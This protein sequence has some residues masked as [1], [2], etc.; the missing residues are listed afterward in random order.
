MLGF[1][2]EHLSVT[3]LN[4]ARARQPLR[5]SI[6]LTASTDLACVTNA[7]SDEVLGLVN[8]LCKVSL[9]PHSVSRTLKSVGLDLDKIDSLR[10]PTPPLGRGLVMGELDVSGALGCRLARAL[11]R[12]R[13]FPPSGQVLV[14]AKYPPV[15]QQRQR[16]A[17]DY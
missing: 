17:S 7:F 1:V 16:N 12:V 10:T 2:P 3:P 6:L 15:G 14:A 9:A 4:D 5:L 8:R 11:A 13:A